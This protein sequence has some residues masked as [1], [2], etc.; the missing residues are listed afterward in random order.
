M[1]KSLGTHVLWTLTHGESSLGL[2]TVFSN[3][4]KLALNV[5]TLLDNVG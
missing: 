2:C 5:V 1:T 4:L 3:K